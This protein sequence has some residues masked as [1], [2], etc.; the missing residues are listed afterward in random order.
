[1][2]SNYSSKIQLVLPF[3][4]WQ[5]NE[6]L[7]QIFELG[8]LKSAYTNYIDDNDDEV[9][10]INKQIKTREEKLTNLDELFNLQVN[11]IKTN[12]NRID[13]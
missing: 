2:E 6:I 1:M 7:R 3:I 11:D 10:E 12:M 9:S 8:E 5:T 4:I 13:I